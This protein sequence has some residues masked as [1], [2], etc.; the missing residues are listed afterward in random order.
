MYFQLNI[1]PVKEEW[2]SLI[3]QE[4]KPVVNEPKII[5]ETEVPEIEK[6][7]TEEQVHEL[8][9]TIA[10]GFFFFLIYYIMQSVF[11]TM[12]RCVWSWLS[13]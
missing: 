12:S 4:P 3:K 8:N 10:S 6:E 5:A 2:P 13:V 1:Q 11:L 9:N 7:K